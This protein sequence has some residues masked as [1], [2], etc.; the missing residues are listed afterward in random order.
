[1]S[2]STHLAL[3]L[4]VALGGAIG[5][6]LRYH[7]AGV[8]ASRLGDR[9]PWGTLVV[10]VSGAALIGAL[11]GLI[12]VRP[13]I[14]GAASALWLV[15]AV[16]VLGSYTTVSSFSLQTLALLRAGDPGRAFANVIGSLALC[17]AAAM[18]GYAGAARLLAG[19]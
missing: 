9:F 17:L 18:L 7:V 15:L 3:I 16:G 8:V 11:A 10:N 19:G 4:P 5:G 12:P 14:E 1:M 6:V 13:G 2:M